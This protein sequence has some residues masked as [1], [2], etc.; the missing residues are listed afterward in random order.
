M[1]FKYFVLI[2]NNNTMNLT[3]PLVR[4]CLEIRKFKCYFVT[5]KYKNTL[6]FVTKKTFK[7]S[8][9]TIHTNI[10]K[11]VFNKIWLEVEKHEYIYIF[12]IKFEK[13]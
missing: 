3:F 7:E 8:T 6:N 11:E 1:V 10:V 13:K 2:S 4:T 9:L 5:R 12:E